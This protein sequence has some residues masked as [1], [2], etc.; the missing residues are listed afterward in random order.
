MINLLQSQGPSTLVNMA[1][2]GGMALVMYFFMLRPQSKKAKAQKEFNTG[3]KV[4]DRIV[5][6]GGIHGKIAAINADGTMKMECERGATMIIEAS[7]V[8]MEMTTAFLAKLNATSVET[9]K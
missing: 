6:I 3:T 2:L 9:A 7:A 8:S 4:G 5:T 1:L